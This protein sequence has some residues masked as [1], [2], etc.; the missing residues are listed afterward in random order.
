MEGNHPV[1]KADLEDTENTEEERNRGRVSVPVVPAIFAGRRQEMGSTTE[2]AEN[3]ERM[4]LRP[5]TMTG[6]CLL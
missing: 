1:R 6:A 5:T 2:Y 3:A 4:W